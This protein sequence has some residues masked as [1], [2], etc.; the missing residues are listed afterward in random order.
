MKCLAL[1][2]MIFFA[3]GAQATSDNPTT[4]VDHKLNKDTKVGTPGVHEVRIDNFQNDAVDDI[5]EVEFA[6]EKFLE[7]SKDGEDQT[8]DYTEPKDKSDSRDQT[9]CNADIEGESL[10][11]TYSV[12]SSEAVGDHGGIL[13]SEDI[14]QIQTTQ[15]LAEH[16]ST[17]KKSE[18]RLKYLENKAKSVAASV[19][20]GVS[21]VASTIGEATSSIKAKVGSYITSQTYHE[22]YRKKVTISLP[23]KHGPKIYNRI[24]RYRIADCNLTYS[25]VVTVKI[26]STSRANHEDTHLFMRFTQL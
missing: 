22:V 21:S 5:T 6:S 26:T 23:F 8:E 25:P 14:N 15:T 2:K 12:S 1:T 11:D 13:V 4:A 20:E 16:K 17:K 7:K 24:I 3:V 9:E 10:S 19:L 18:G